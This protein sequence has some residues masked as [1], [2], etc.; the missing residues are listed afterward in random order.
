MGFALL[1]PPYASSPA[2]ASP[3]LCSRQ[4]EKNGV[5]VTLRHADLPTGFHGAYKQGNPI[6]ATIHHVNLQLTPLSMKTGC[7]CEGQSPEAISVGGKKIK[8]LLRLRLATTEKKGSQRQKRRARNNR[9]EGPAMIQGRAIF[10]TMTGNLHRSIY[11]TT[12]SGRLAVNS[13]SQTRRKVP[14]PGSTK[15]PFVFAPWSRFGNEG[16]HRRG[17]PSHCKFQHISLP[18]NFLSPVSLYIIC[19]K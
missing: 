10:A 7:L 5:L 15:A 8:R 4:I 18:A 1:H 2:E 3:S 6:F 11:P 9:K 13:R 14:T 17:E 19:T 16:G 12:D